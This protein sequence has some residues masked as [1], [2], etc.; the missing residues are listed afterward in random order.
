MVSLDDIEA[1]LDETEAILEGLRE[2][3]LEEGAGGGEE[4]EDRDGERGWRR[5]R[6]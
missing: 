6:G 1:D 4:E 5:G 3:V 2:A